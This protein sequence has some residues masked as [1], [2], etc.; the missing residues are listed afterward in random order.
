MTK[1]APD[2]NQSLRILRDRGVPVGTVIDVGVCHCTAELMAVWPDRKHL[3]FEPVAEFVTTIEHHYRNIPHELHSVAVSDEA[4]TIG[5]KVSSVLSGM[6]VS[7]SGMTSV[8]YS[9]N[10]AIRSVPMIKLDD[11]LLGRELE[12]PYLLKIDIDGQELKVLKG[13][14]ET[15]KKC[16][17]V[18]V[19]CQSSQLVQRIA[20]VQAA[21][22]SLFDLA[23]PCYYDKV[24]WQCDAVFIRKDIAI[25]KFKLLA[26]KVEAGMYEMFRVLS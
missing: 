18:I 23:E 11:F 15:L 7:H 14:A 19:E 4:G 20:A 6:E 10:P 2:K 12:E 3:L 13:A 5:L 8:K 26:G 9:D 17:I 24:F 21:G 22:F 25:S 1:R 16:S